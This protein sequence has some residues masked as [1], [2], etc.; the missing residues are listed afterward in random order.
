MEPFRSDVA[1]EIRRKR[2][3][4]MEAYS[5]WQLHL[6]DIFDRPKEVVAAE[7]ETNRPALLQLLANRAP[8]R[9]IFSGALARAAADANPM[10]RNFEEASWEGRPY[11]RGPQ[12]A[13][14]QCGAS[15]NAIES[16]TLASPGILSAVA[17]QE[18]ARDRLCRPPVAVAA[19]GDGRAVAVA[20]AGCR[21]TPGAVGAAGPAQRPG[22]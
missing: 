15:R 2:V 7:V 20:G 14:C 19:L 11:L 3:E 22:P 9:S 18:R 6:D 13:N 12:E 17:G 5:L 4:R 10:S 16:Q 21:A 8:G 1:A